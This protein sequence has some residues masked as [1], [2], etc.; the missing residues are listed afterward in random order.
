MVPGIKVTLYTNTSIGNRANPG[1]GEVDHLASAPG[2]V[3]GSGSVTRSALP[4]RAD[5]IVW[6][7]GSAVGK[8]WIAR[9]P[10][11]SDI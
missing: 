2:T 1:R 6:C 11:V 9:E 3:T 10:Y 5:V 4:P 8:G 7:H